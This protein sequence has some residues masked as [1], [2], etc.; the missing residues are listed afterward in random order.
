MNALRLCTTLYWKKGFYMMCS[1]P[2]NP[3]D[4]L[5]RSSLLVHERKQPEQW[6]SNTASLL[7]TQ[8]LKILIYGLKPL[9]SLRTEIVVNLL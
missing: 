1:N 7:R 8:G 2:F 6:L 3:R 4:S 9:T 5:I